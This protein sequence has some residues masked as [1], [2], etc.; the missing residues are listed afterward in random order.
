MSLYRNILKRAWE[1]TWKFK[2]LWFFG[3]F[4]ALLGNGG[5][6]E[7]ISKSFDINNPDNLNI[8]DSIKSFAGTGIFSK[9]AV[10]NVGQLVV[11][12]PFNLLMLVI[13]LL[14]VLILAGFMIWLTIISQAAL[15]NN[16]ANVISGKPHDLKSGVMNGADKFWP[17]FGMNLISRALT[18]LVFL[19]IGLPVVISISR[20][21][22]VTASIVFI[23][24]FLIFIP[25]AII[26]SFIV[27]YSIGYII[28]K[29][30]KF[31]ESLKLGWLLFIK[32]W[33]ISIEMAFI[34]FFINFFVGIFL[35][36]I[37]L[38][39]AIPFL[40][41]LFLLIKSGLFFNF[42]VVAMFALVLFL[43]IIILVGSA[44]SVFQISSW[45]GLFIELVG[46]GGVSK[47]VRLFDKKTP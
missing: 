28:I 35:I 14:I 21:N 29:G 6:F 25:V 22:A 34:L 4:A 12:D 37:L 47:I 5:E 30:E 31:L 42:W 1:I 33:L 40:F 9:Q 17:V 39:L 10:G 20:A 2:Y 16:S 32:N 45:T 26:L 18:Y 41:I 46:R 23:V 36:L 27:K 43:I 11:N 8:I 15:V 3:L 13:I 38:I 24:S 44:L 7:I 19:A